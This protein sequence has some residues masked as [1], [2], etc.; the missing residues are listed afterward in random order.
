[1]PHPSHSGEPSRR[2]RP[3]TFDREAAL[4]AA[5]RLFWRHGYEGTSIADLTAAM[6]TTPPTLYAEFGS[7]EDLFRAVLAHYHDREGGRRRAELIEREPSAHRA[8]ENLLRD[9]ARQY[10]NP[11][12]PAGCMV[13]AS[14]LQ[15]AT[16]NQAAANVVSKFRAASTRVLR[17][18]FSEAK[19]SGQ[20]PKTTDTTALAGFY[21]AVVQGM[22]VQACSGANARALNGIVDIAMA[23]WPGKRP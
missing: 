5:V 7:K 19:Q 20:L 18:K 21:A 1:M 22:S 16:E 4:D 8:T 15:C 9:I 3:R 13:A 17:A 10:A 6:K 23:A 12:N 2:G 14:T 11:S